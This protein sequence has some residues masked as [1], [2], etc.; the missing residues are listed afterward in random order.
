MAMKQRSLAIATALLA[1]LLAAGTAWAALSSS[2]D[3]SWWSVDAGGSTFSTAEGY[4]LGGS[5]G[6]PDA[7]VLSGGYTLAG[8]FWGGG[9]AAEGGYIYLPLVL[10]S[11]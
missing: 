1:T 6:Q 2:Y 9:A 5:I 4:T 11:G 8:G 7:A 10:R 3:L